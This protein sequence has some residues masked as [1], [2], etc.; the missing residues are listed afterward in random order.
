VVVEEEDKLQ[1]VVQAQ[2]VQVA[3]A[4]VE[5]VVL[6]VKL[7]KAEA[8]AA[9]VGHQKVVAQLEMVEKEL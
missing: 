5:L 7:I 2:V 9:Q 8:E 6:Q 1:V 4:L 3:V